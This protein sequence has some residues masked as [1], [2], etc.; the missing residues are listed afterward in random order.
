[1]LYASLER[2][3]LESRG[4]GLTR[5]QPQEHRRGAGDK[6]APRGAFVRVGRSSQ[7]RR[8]GGWAEGQSASSRQSPGTEDRG[9]THGGRDRGSR[10]G[11]R[12]GALP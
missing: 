5:Q 2:W 3:E 4:W 6:D 11:V 7:D 10:A 1:M 12:V 9:R 8:C